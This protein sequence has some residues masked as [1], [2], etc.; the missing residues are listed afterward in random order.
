MMSLFSNGRNSNGIQVR[1][2]RDL[3]CQKLYHL[4][5]GLLKQ[6]AIYSQEKDEGLETESPYLFHHT[7][8]AKD[9]QIFIYTTQKQRFVDSLIT[10]DNLRCS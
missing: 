5:S 3:N 10:I 4:I 8:L 2:L 7:T 6:I 9:K 1:C